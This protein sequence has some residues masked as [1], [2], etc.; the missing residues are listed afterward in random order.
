MGIW[1]QKGTTYLIKAIEGLKS[2]NRIKLVLFGKFEDKE[3]LELARSKDF[4]TL[5]GWCDRLKTLELL[6]LSDIACWP[7]HHTTLIEDCIAVETPIVI[8]RTGTTEHLINSNGV[9]LKQ[10]SKEELKDVIGQYLIQIKREDNSIA[11]KSMKDKLSYNNIA[12]TIINVANR[13]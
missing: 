8:R 12:K 2:N 11:C 13:E 5:A 10:G 7:I 9:W 3:T 6:K 1:L 4:I